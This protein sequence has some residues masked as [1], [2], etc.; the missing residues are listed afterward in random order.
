MLVDE[1]ALRGLAIVA[2][3]SGPLTCR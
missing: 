2:N 1:R 3:P